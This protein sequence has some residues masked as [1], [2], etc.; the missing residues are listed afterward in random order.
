MVACSVIGALAIH[1]F[2]LREK[3][4][5]L[6]LRNRISLST[7]PL[8]LNE[9]Q[10]FNPHRD[11]T[12]RIPLG[13]EEPCLFFELDLAETLDG[14]QDLAVSLGA[15]QVRRGEFDLTFRFFDY[16]FLI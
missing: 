5:R 4:Q 3:D 12:L 2:L 6:S 15:S 9:A 7:I 16:D 14:L 1:F 11:G 13:T 10:Q 8:R